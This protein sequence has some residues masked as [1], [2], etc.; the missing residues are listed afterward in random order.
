MAILCN[1]YDA[2]TESS[3]GGGAT[4]GGGGSCLTLE[5]VCVA[6]AVDTL[7]VH[8]LQPDQGVG[9]HMLAVASLHR[10]YILDTIYLHGFG[11]C[12]RG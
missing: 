1:K 9:R 7:Q 11:A 5:N 2:L 12:T 8:L 6:L 10:K 4:S 3:T